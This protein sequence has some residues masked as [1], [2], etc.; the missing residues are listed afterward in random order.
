MSWNQLIQTKSLNA[1][2]GDMKEGH[3]L[4]RSLGPISLTAMGVGAIIGT[5]IFV[6]VGKDTAINYS[7]ATGGSVTVNT[8]SFFPTGFYFDLPA[9][10][11]TAIVTCILVRGVTESAFTNAI[12]VAIKVSVVLFVIVAG[13]SYVNVE[14]WTRD[15]APYGYGG[16]TFFGSPMFGGTDKGMMAGAAGVIF[17]WDYS[18]C[19]VDALAAK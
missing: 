19:S 6:L 12:M 9:I 15:F 3:S 10:L 11:I 14:N 18:L 8:G 1:I 5:G 17:A 4:K 16:I 2:V 7:L 13:I